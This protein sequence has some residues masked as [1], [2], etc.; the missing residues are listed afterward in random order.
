MYSIGMLYRIPK[1]WKKEKK[2]NSID[3]LHTLRWNSGL[4][5][6][7]KLCPQREK[8]LEV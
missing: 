2:D 7:R 4:Y 1:K 6:Y 8:Y 5:K 3:L